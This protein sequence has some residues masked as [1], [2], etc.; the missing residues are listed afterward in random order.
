MVRCRRVGRAPIVITHAGGYCRRPC[1]ATRPGRNWPCGFSARERER[2]RE[3]WREGEREGALNSG[4]ALVQVPFGPWKVARTVLESARRPTPSNKTTSYVAGA[5]SE[6][7]LWA[8]NH[9]KPIFVQPRSLRSIPIRTLKNYYKTAWIPT[10]PKSSAG[11]SKSRRPFPGQAKPLRSYAGRHFER[12]G[13]WSLSRGAKI[14]C[15][16]D[17]PSLPQKD[18]YFC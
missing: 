11:K 1:D 18:S 9:K 17:V 15:P 10:S 8:T 13:A 7:S 12:A 16:F 3:R 14:K 6:A 5:V 4:S 2:G